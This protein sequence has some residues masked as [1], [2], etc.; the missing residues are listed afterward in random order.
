MKICIAVPHAL[1]IAAMSQPWEY[2]MDGNA[3][4][5]AVALADSLGY[6]KALMGEHFIIPNSHVAASG[7]FWH[8]GTV[9]LSAVAGRTRHI[10]LQS[11]ITLLPLQ[12]PVVQAKAWSTLDWMSGGR[13]TPV[14]AVGWLKEEFEMMNVP[15]HKRGRMADEYI[16][17]IHALW[18]DEC[19]SFAGEFVNFTDAAYAPKPVRKPHMPIWFGGDSAPVLGRI[20]KWG[21]GWIPFLTPPEKF[22]E[23]LDTIRAHRD[24]RGQPLDMFFAIEQMALGEGHVEKEIAIKIDPWHVDQ[25]VDLCGQ[26]AD[27]GVTETI[28]PLPRLEG[29]EAYLDRLRW[30]AEEIIPRVS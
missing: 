2:A 6:H 27:L 13:A 30:V 1:E 4:L 14:F 20:A 8:H 7:A 16:A 5:D 26:L 29:V 24:Y 21:D 12:H 28:V 18:N 9:A 17:A 11:S 22:P 23:A 19:P 3:V 25:L 10:G 15:F